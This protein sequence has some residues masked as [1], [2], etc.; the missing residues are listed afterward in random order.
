MR[1]RTTAQV[2][3]LALAAC[4]T[5]AARHLPD[6][7]IQPYVGPLPESL[8]SASEAH[9]RWLEGS[10]AFTERTADAE[11]RTI[12]RLRGIPDDARSE[13]AEIRKVN[14]LL[15]DYYTRTEK[16]AYRS[17]NARPKL[18]VA[19]SGGG[20]RAAAFAIG[21]LQGLQEK[22]KLTDVDI[23]SAVSGGA[24]ALTWYYQNRLDGLSDKQT[25]VDRRLQ[26]TID[27]KVLSVPVAVLGFAT[28]FLGVFHSLSSTANGI[29][30]TT[31]SSSYY[32]MLKKS[33]RAKPLSRRRLQ[34]HVES[35]Q[36][37]LPIIGLAAFPV[38]GRLS[39]I[40]N[41]EDAL[42]SHARSVA[43]N[44]TYMEI[45]PYRRGLNGFGFQQGDPAPLP[46]D[47]WEYA[48]LSGA[49]YDEPH[50]PG[51]LGRRSTT[52]RLGSMMSMVVARR[53]PNAERITSIE[54][55][56]TQLFYVT[57]GGFVENLAAFPLVLRGCETILIADAEYDPEWRFEG[58]RV[59]KTRLR[60][61]HSLRLDVAGI[62]DL[63]N[64]SRPQ[65]LCGRADGLQLPCPDVAC[66]REL[67]STPCTA[68]AAKTNVFRGTVTLPPTTS[69]EIA[70]PR[71][72]RVIYLKLGLTAEE[73][74]GRRP[75]SIWP[76][77]EECLRKP[78]SCFFPQDK[79]FD[80]LDPKKTQRY[81]PE[82]FAAYKDLARHIVTTIA[83]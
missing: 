19:L 83:W 9:S 14:R 36:V 27:S 44:D 18:C 50:K 70:A 34:E 75:E 13:S 54:A 81:T 57:D 5:V 2:S 63:V 30:P 62:D 32:G 11:I 74:A 49:A 39:E 23:I 17:K 15:S 69:E 21:T 67:G 8:R 40:G 60:G 56:R 73:L 31:L 59:L 43:L 6:P 25:L 46:D 33:F 72:S 48:L 47:L 26:E 77:L 10:Q 53:Y 3:I 71:S 76:Y 16:S 80:E 55:V 12:A 7:G 78:E 68:R 35:G 64:R 52:D 41:S 58:Y 42:V 22:E 24:W 61:E 20:I 4:T 65:A 37:P 1:L 66:A 28:G 82:Q 29:D 38:A 45:T 79:T 51:S